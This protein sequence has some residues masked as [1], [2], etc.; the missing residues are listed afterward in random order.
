M[1]DP[2]G[3]SK[4]NKAPM[5]KYRVLSWAVLIVV[6]GLLVAF[7]AYQNTITK[8]LEIV[9]FAHNN[10]LSQASNLFTQELSDIRTTIRLINQQIEHPVTDETNADFVAPLFIQTAHTLPKLLQLRWINNNGIERVRVNSDS[11]NR[12]Y[13]VDESQLQDKSSRYYVNAGLNLA[14]GQVY[15][16]KID[17]N[18]EKGTI[19][20]P[21]QPTIRAVTKSH[22]AGTNLN[23]I[24]VLNYNLSGILQRL[25]EVSS[26]QAQLIIS[27]GTERIILHPDKQHEWGPDLAIMNQSLEHV[28][29]G[30]AERISRSG[31]QIIFATENGQKYSAITLHSLSGLSDEQLPSLYIIAKTPANVMNQIKTDALYSAMGVGL[32]IVALGFATLYRDYRY[33]QQLIHSSALLHKEKGELKQT[34]ERQ[35]ALMDELSESKKLSS[36]GMMVAGL[37][38]ELNTPIGAARLAVSESDA[39]LKRLIKLKS[40]GLTKQAFDTYIENSQQS[41]FLT[42]SNLSRAAEIITSFKHLTQERALDTLSEF[43]LHQIVT[44]FLH[45]YQGVLRKEGVKIHHS[46]DPE[47]MLNG[48][49][50]ILS[51]V[52]QCL[53]ENSLRHAFKSEQEKRIDITAELIDNKVSIIFADNG[54]GLSAEQIELVF[55][56]FYTTSRGSGGTGLGLYIAHQW[57]T[58]SLQGSIHVVKNSEQG[59]KFEIILPVSPKAKAIE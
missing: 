41:I 48:Y 29:P 54:R 57:V 50:G 55:D 31:G 36:L 22:I 24:L 43:Y 5:L 8:K 53:I 39:Q 56:P 4:Q 21:F 14:E 15:L 2:Q 45:S 34:I 47:I 19:V 33:S 46:I 37:A 42:F 7:L 38:H 12:I 52:I 44:D 49:P 11:D 1:S 58:K 10:A 25:R 51:Q 6:C 59:A 13:L 17:L 28:E 32:L 3:A 20:T 16:S 9:E 40:N 27:S 35:N 30:I 18:I 26:S 23:G